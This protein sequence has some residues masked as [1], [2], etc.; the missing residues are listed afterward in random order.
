MHAFEVIYCDDDVMAVNKA[1]GLP[2]HAL[3]QGSS[4]AGL[5]LIEAVAS[6]FPEVLSNFPGDREGGLC[7]RLDNGTSGILLIARHRAA[8]DIYREL[9]S[10]GKIEKSYLAIVQG[11]IRDEIEIRFPIAHHP[12]NARKMIALTTPTTR[13]RS[14]AK[15]AQTQG[16][17][18]L[19]NDVAS[20]VR[21]KI[22]A[23]RRH[24]IRV[25]LA[26]IG[27]PLYGDT[28]YKGPTV[29]YILGHALHASTLRLP[30][31][32]WLEAPCPTEW[33][34]ELKHLCL[35]VP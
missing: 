7:H 10:Q 20:L 13:H 2:C 23:G 18:L 9:F 33:E 15:Q 3:E 25:H 31:G 4:Q 8:R 16:R 35:V 22:G 6:E 28:L 27:H 19:S 24:Q 17:A 34:D 32:R 14:H 29:S 26:S 5:S 21:V 11:S 1:P 30:D 12:K